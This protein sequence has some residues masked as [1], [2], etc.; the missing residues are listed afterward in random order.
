MVAKKKHHRL[1]SYSK[2]GKIPCSEYFT[3]DKAVKPINN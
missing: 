1:S 3:Q 2:L